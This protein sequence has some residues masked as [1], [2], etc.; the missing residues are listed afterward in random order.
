M[1][2]YRRLG[3][4][5]RH[6]RLRAGLTQPQLA[7]L[8]KVSKG[9]I[10]RWETGYARPSLDRLEPLAKRL[11]VSI[12]ILLGFAL[13][14]ESGTYRARTLPVWELG[15]EIIPDFKEASAVGE[16]LT[17]EQEALAVEAALF[18][19]D[20]SF[21]PHFLEGDI[22]GINTKGKP[23]VGEVVFIKQGGKILMRR[24]G[25]RRKNE[26]LLPMEISKDMET[27]SRLNHIGVFRWLHRPGHLIL[28]KK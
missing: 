28:P 13:T 3:E 1:G 18:I 22:V 8:L 10:S 14:E 24:Y 9:I 21:A 23:R 2:I 17:S 25:G 12:E 19:K 11:G 6:A 26:I 20:N 16:V 5:I 15:A 7:E 4:R 27:P